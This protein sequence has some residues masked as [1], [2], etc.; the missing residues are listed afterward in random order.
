MTA[1]AETL[2]LGAPLRYFLATARAGSF[3]GASDLVHIA[4][5]SILRQ[6]TLLEESLGMPLFV[7]RR[8]RNTLA[9]TR[10]G[11]TLLE[12]A[13]RI[14]DE[15]TRGLGAVHGLNRET[16]SRLVIGTSDALAHDV[17]PDILSALR[18][19]HPELAFDLQISEPPALIRDLVSGTIDVVFAYDVVP[20]IGITTLA[21]FRLPSSAVMQPDHPLAGR[22]ELTL[23]EC[24]GFPLVLP[25]NPIYWGP[26]LRKLPRRDDT[27]L[28]RT[29]SWLL[30]RDLVTRDNMIAFQTN[31]GARNR[32]IDNGLVCIP[33]R[34]PMANYSVLSVCLRDGTETARTP[35]TTIILNTIRQH[36]HAAREPFDK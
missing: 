11:E 12:H 2:M 9:L 31:P 3:R 32:H 19:A 23:A 27:P 6:I 15:V 35:F 20:Q 30:M 13:I 29:N 34:D 7:R 21:E 17:L 22:T 4:P 10:A 14:Q 36:I 16:G 8:G 24:G 1:F 5:S 28:I 33:L 26:I 18:Q 25:M